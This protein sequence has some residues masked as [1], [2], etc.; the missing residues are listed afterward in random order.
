MSKLS[1]KEFAKIEIESGD[2]DPDYIFIN[3]V[4]AG[5]SRFKADWIIAKTIIYDSES[6]LRFLLN[7]ES[8]ETLNYGNERRKHKRHAKEYLDSIFQIA[9]SDP[10]DFFI[11]LP[12]N[13][14]EAMEKIKMA[15]G[16]GPWA[17]WKTIDLVG[18][19]LDIEFNFDD[20]DFRGAY[21]YPIKGMLMVAGMDEQKSRNVSDLDYKTAFRN[22]IDALGSAAH[23]KPPCGKRDIINIQ[24]IE[25]ILCKYHSYVHGHYEPLEDLK[26]LKQRITN[27]KYLNIRNFKNCLP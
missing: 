5:D 14:Y 20:F 18:C 22:V 1:V 27:S 8:L 3:N 6:E 2:L 26:R 4:A 10:L 24:E 19:C 16:F 9:D 11:N 23:L 25:T 12:K 21:D 7:N 15:K 13:A 17:A